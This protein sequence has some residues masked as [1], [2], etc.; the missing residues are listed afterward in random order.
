MLSMKRPR[1]SIEI[2]TLAASSVFRRAILA[3]THF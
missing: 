3:L 1:P 2:A